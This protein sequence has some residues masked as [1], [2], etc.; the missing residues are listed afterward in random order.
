ML[1]GYGYEGRVKSFISVIL[2]LKKTSLG[3]SFL[4]ALCSS[5]GLLFLH[6]NYPNRF[7][8]DGVVANLLRP[9][10]RL[11]FY[12]GTV[13]FPNYSTPH[14]NGFYLVPLF[15]VIASFL[16]WWMPF[17]LCIK[18]L[19]QLRPSGRERTTG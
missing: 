9:F 17:F 15:G 4:L 3:L 2:W 5:F 6:I 1:P 19:N 10:N 11:G 18:I 7:L 16:V 14:T 12:L 13:L 8:V